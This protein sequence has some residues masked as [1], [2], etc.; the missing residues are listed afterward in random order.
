MIN[1]HET[2]L[3]KDLDH[4]RLYVTREFDAPIE[5]LWRAWTES[6]I[7]DQWWAPKP[8]KMHTVSQEFKPGGR[9]L[10]YMEAPN[11]AR[12]YCLADYKQIIPQKSYEVLDAFCD[13]N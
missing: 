8:Y 5:Q 9:W 12:H 6:K 11:G 2:K 1:I 3:V 4:K 10:Y 7:T 13:E